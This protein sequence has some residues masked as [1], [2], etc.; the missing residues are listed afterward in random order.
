MSRDAEAKVDDLIATINLHELYQRRLV[1]GRDLNDWHT[2][3]R[4]W[5]QQGELDRCLELLAEIIEVIEGLDWLDAREPQLYWY[6]K[7][8]VLMAR[9]GRHRAAIVL[10][11]RWLSF[12]PEGRGVNPDMVQ[13]AASKRGQ[14]HAR[15]ERLERAEA[16]R[17]AR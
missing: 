3:L 7:S 1:R 12:W 4:E 17:R 16:T 6:E 8:A 13:V 9:Q 15:I 14:V 10:L 2:Q 5:Q 11:R